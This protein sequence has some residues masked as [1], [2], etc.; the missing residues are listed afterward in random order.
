MTAPR[1]AL[2]AKGFRPFFLG[3][4]FFAILGMGLWMAVYLF[5][6][7]VPMEGMSEFQ[8]HAHEM[9]FGYT[10]AVIAGFLLTAVQ[11]WTGEKTATGGALAIMFLLWLAARLLMLS[12]SRFLPVAGV[13][14]ML[15]MLG[16]AASVFRPIFK[17]RQKRQVP[18]VVI[19]CLLTIANGMFYLG[20]TEVLHDGVRLAVYTGFYGMLGMVLFMGRRVIPFFTERGLEPRASVKNSRWNDLATF[21]IFPLFMISE[22]VAPFDM[23][24]AVLAGAL[25]VLNSFRVGGWY[26]LAIWQKPLLWGLFA[27]SVMINLG[28]ML[29]GL[30]QVTAIPNYLPIHAFALGGV[31]I[32]TLSMM[33]RV[34]LG[35]T[36]RN[37]KT[38]PPIMTLLLIGMLLS[39]IFRL[40]FPLL[41]PSHYP[42][43]VAMAALFWM[44]SFGLFALL[45]TPM[46]LRP[47]VDGKPG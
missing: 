34:T 26:N 45:F 46:L 1:M 42:L 18:V 43:W 33:A 5:R 8:W 15:F 11:N 22:L 40:F 24:G 31:G 32:I 17:A 2:F 37:I 14:D 13:A 28:F 23:P 21:I 35:H 41:D 3:A 19:V 39:T 25:F 47:R 12:G 16:L 44:I 20:A 30:M 29:R 10:M 6:L 9:I 4:A 38:P 27:A 7:S 36:G